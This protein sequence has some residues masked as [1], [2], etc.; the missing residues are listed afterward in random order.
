VVESTMSD[1][2]STM[3]QEQENGK[4]PD[5]MMIETY[6]FLNRCYA[7]L[8]VDQGDLDQA[9]K[10]LHEMLANDENDRFAINELARIRRIRSGE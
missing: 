6:G 7:R 10:I 9:E 3:E 1:M 4:S 8:L 5:D 2:R